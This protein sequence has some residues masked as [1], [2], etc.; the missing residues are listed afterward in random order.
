MR[1]IV[2]FRVVAA[3]V[4]VVLAATVTAA[5]FTEKLEEVTDESTVVLTTIG[6]TSGDP[7][8]VTI[9][10]VVDGGRLFLQSGKG[11][12]TDWYRNLLENPD[13]TLNFEKRQIEGKARPV[14]DPEE[15]KRIHE[16]FRDKYFLA[17]MSGWVGGGFGHGEV[18]E[19]RPLE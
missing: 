14:D 6:R 1:Q 17:Q 7:H 15:A 8:R 18:V 19:I 2:L 11:G 9:W 12:K 4:G 13:V 5:G 16:R 10:F 3:F